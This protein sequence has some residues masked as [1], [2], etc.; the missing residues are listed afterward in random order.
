MTIGS[1]L[2][3][4]LGLVCFGIGAAGV[5]VTICMVPFISASD[6]A[7]PA[8]F[9]VFGPCFNGLL[10]CCYDGCAGTMTNFKLM[11]APPKP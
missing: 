5:I 2:K 1:A 10:F 7:V 4:A 9:G 3:I 11:D 6:A 8:M